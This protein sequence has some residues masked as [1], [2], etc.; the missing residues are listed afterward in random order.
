M[1]EARSSVEDLVAG[2]ASALSSSSVDLVDG[3]LGEI[4]VALVDEGRSCPFVDALIAALQSPSFRA[5]PQSGRL[6]SL[7]DDPFLWEALASAPS[8]RSRLL[9]SMEAAYPHFADWMS[10]FYITEVLGD[11]EDQ[12]EALGILARLSEVGSPVARALVANGLDGVARN[13]R[14]PL[15]ADSAVAQLL[16]MSTD[17]DPAVRDEVCASL[18]RLLSRLEAEPTHL[19]AHREG[20]LRSALDS[21]LNSL[22]E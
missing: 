3:I 22:P 18:G 4:H 1:A 6:L 10:C 2:L 21:V 7:L 9:A 15:A 11:L 20:E 17:A 19:L 14:D 12:R 13:A 16:A 5:A 8:Q